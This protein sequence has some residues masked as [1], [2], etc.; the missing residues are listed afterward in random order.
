VVGAAGAIGACMVMLLSERAPRLVLIGNPAHEPAI[1]RERLLAIARSMVRHALADPSRGVEA[2]SLAAQIV[3]HSASGAT[4]E[5]MLL[6]LE[7]SGRLILTASIQAAAMADV[8]V[9]ATS[10]PGQLFNPD[11]MARNAVI[12]DVSRPRSIGESILQRRPDV[13]VI[14]GGI[15]A[16]PGRPRIGPYGLEDGTSYACMAETM[17]LALEG[18]PQ[19]TSLGHALDAAEVQR[20]QRLARKH[21][22]SLSSLRSFG[23]PVKLEA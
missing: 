3:E 15:V 19:D 10:F 5:E 17:L 16:L 18:D 22:F 23:R 8:I 4:P 20:Q 13:L 9:A 1:G 12:C 6:A 2:A 14:D 21:G 7:S 11:L